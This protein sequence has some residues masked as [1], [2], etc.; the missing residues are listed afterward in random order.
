MSLHFL[1]IKIIEN[2]IFLHYV[3]PKT[4]LEQ[5]KSVQVNWTEFNSKKKENTW[6]HKSVFQAIGGEI[7]FDILIKTMLKN[8]C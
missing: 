6:S 1:W 8:T 7:D 3:R 4:N 5:K 2:G